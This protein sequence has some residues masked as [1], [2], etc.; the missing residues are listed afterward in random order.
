MNAGLYNTA[1]RKQS[2]FPRVVAETASIGRV[3]IPDHRPSTL[4]QRQLRETMDAQVATKSRP[5]IRRRQRPDHQKTE[6]GMEAREQPVVFDDSDTVLQQKVSIGNQE[7]GQN[8]EG[9]SNT[10][11]EKL[12]EKG[13]LTDRYKR[14]YKNSRELELHV[15]GQP[16]QVGLLKDLAI[17][18]RLPFPS[19]EISMNPR[20]FLIGENHQMSPI[21]KIVEES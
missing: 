12:Y 4:Y 10:M 5:L 16:V 8:D 9:L 14:T 6:N 1:E 18:Y 2:R 21:R 11:K 20:F 19:E 13:W 3:T 7:V 17:W 15:T